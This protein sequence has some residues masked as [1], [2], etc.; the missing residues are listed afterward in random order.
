MAQQGVEG[1]FATHKNIDMPKPEM[2]KIDKILEGQ[3]DTKFD[4]KKD[5]MH[6]LQEGMKLIGNEKFQ[7]DLKKIWSPTIFIFRVT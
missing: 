1:I 7:G 4:I 6:N 5:P 3:Y 2:P